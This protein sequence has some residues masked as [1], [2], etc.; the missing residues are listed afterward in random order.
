MR[1]VLNDTALTYSQPLY[2]TL[3]VEATHHQH[4]PTIPWPLNR[5][6]EAYKRDDHH[7]GLPA[8]LVCVYEERLA[9]GTNRWHPVHLPA[10]VRTK[11]SFPNSSLQRSLNLPMPGASKD[12]IPLFSRQAAVRLC[13]GLVSSNTNVSSNATTEASTS[14]I[15]SGC[16][17][18]RSMQLQQSIYDYLWSKDCL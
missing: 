7:S 18:A 13:N 1:F 14:C 12:P 9:Y 2:V 16:R 6:T 10:L 11:L 5:C 3:C 15:N 17:C 8:K 4:H